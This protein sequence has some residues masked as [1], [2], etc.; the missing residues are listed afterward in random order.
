MKTKYY[1][2]ITLGDLKRQA[3]VVYNQTKNTNIY[4]RWMN[5]PDRDDE[6]DTMLPVYEKFKEFM[7]IP[8]DNV[9][10]VLLSRF[11]IDFCFLLDGINALI[12]REGEECIIPLDKG[13]MQYCFSFPS[14][15]RRSFNSGIRNDDYK[16]YD[17]FMKNFLDIYFWR[18]FKQ[19]EVSNSYEI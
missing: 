14:D 7:D 11:D 10:R 12:D 13:S 17:Y 18:F 9:S 19:E 3:L 15:I 5:L 16:T 8:D 6:N 2:L 4:K 1:D